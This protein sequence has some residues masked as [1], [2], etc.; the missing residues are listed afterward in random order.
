MNFETTGRLHEKY[1]TQV[2][3]D[4]FRKREFI[5]EIKETGNNG[6]EFIEYIK[7]QLT[8]DK[9]MLLD[10]IAPGEELKITF[11]L[12]GRKWEK[13]GTVSYFTNLEAWKIEKTKQT[14]VSP[15]ASGS[16]GSTPG[17]DVPFPSD[18]PQDDTGFDDLPF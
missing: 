4:K 1:E 2:I 10:P 17:S 15:M 14:N 8:Q 11:N 3:S 12:R 16:A 9:C 18:I 5:L 6:F 13:D 7:F